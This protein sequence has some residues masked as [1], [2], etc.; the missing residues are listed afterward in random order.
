M[1]LCD[2][3]IS[4]VRRTGDRDLWL[5]LAHHA[6]LSTTTGRYYCLF[7]WLLSTSKLLGRHGHFYS[8]SRGPQ[9]CI[10]IL[11]R[12]KILSSLLLYFDFFCQLE[13]D[14][15]IIVSKIWIFLNVRLNRKIEVW[16][17][18]ACRGAAPFLLFLSLSESDNWAA[19]RIIWTMSR[20]ES[21]LSH[22]LANFR[23]LATISHL[24]LVLTWFKSLFAETFLQFLAISIAIAF[25]LFLFISQRKCGHS[26]LWLILLFLMLCCG[27]WL[28]TSPSFDCLSW[29][30]EAAR[31]LWRL[32]SSHLL[33]WLSYPIEIAIRKVFFT[34]YHL[35][36][37]R[38]GSQVL[39]GSTVN[40]AMLWLIFSCW[41]A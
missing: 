16:F 17:L 33:P 5:T 41:K 22:C 21:M 8:S 20:I 26:I 23:S 37:S 13:C 32:F 27:W 39:F 18:W 25:L 19:A 9:W 24:S 34:F 11:G 28:V 36:C 14:I 3:W 31:G 29:L 4:H 10:F 2:Y 40:K 30:L 38:C 6:S 1:L 7:L 12:L 35:N 15:I